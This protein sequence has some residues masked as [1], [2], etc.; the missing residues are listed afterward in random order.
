[1][2][3]AHSHKRPER[4]G[5]LLRDEIAGILRTHLSDPRLQLLGVTAVEVSGDLQHARVFLSSLDP[6][7]DWPSLLRVLERASGYVRGEL[8]RRR[9]GLRHLPEL[10][11]VPDR[12]IEHGSRIAAI[13]KELPADAPAP[14]S[15]E[16]SDPSDPREESARE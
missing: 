10:A 9:L 6:H 5:D 16:G 1:M 12:S 3:R 15:P 8:G 14:E 11:F 2:N 13:L 7:A 4:V